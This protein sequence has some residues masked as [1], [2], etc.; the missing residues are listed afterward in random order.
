MHKACG[1]MSEDEHDTVRVKVAAA[2]GL[3][4]LRRSYVTAT[5]VD[6]NGDDIGGPV[7]CT[8]K[9]R[10]VVVQHG[11]CVIVPRKGAVGCRFTGHVA[12][13]IR[14]DVTLGS[15]VVPLAAERSTLE[16]AEIRKNG[17]GRPAR[18]KSA[19][20]VCMTED[21]VPS[22]LTDSLTISLP[23]TDTACSFES[24][25]AEGTA[26][27]QRTL[28][29]ADHPTSPIHMHSILPAQG[30]MTSLTEVVARGS[31]VEEHDVEDE[32][33][34]TDDTSSSSSATLEESDSGSK[35][36]T[37]E[38]ETSGMYVLVSAERVSLP[39]RES[40]LEVEVNPVRQRSSKLLSYQG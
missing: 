19:P 21:T 17:S 34:F 23:D 24:D 39:P 2:Y 10:K 6:D 18:Q 5:L 15:V 11:H 13:S 28:S 12:R 16:W 8:L 40:F 37:I 32:L 27:R 9:R 35:L 26:V 14:S 3:S 22:S 36:D 1:T 33:E 31:V 7:L 30:L 25:T 29:L 38:A 20:N 4:A